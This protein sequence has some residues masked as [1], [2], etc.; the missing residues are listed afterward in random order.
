MRWTK[1]LSEI[2][3]TKKVYSGKDSKTPLQWSWAEDTQYPA[4]KS[5]NILKSYGAITSKKYRHVNKLLCKYL[6]TNRARN[7]AYINIGKYVTKL[8][9][10]KI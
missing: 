7:K 1:H 6:S 9:N 5:T 10:I 4:Q 3:M 8:C 2:Y